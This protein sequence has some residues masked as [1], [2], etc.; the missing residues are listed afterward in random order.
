MPPSGLWLS[1]GVDPPQSRGRGLPDPVVGVV[2]ARWVATSTVEDGSAVVAPWNGGGVRVFSSLP[3]RSS[4][5]RQ[6][7][8]LLEAAWRLHSI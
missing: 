8:E 5:F 1:V 4:Q 6:V 3:V 7:V 2:E